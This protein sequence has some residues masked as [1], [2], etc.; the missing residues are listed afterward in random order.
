[1]AT[2]SIGAHLSPPKPSKPGQKLNLYK[3]NSG[4][5][6][7]SLGSKPGPSRPP[8]PPPPSGNLCRTEAHRSPNTK[9][10]GPGMTVCAYLMCWA[11]GDTASELVSSSPAHSRQ[12]VPTP[13]GS[14]QGK[15]QCAHSPL[16]LADPR[17]YGAKPN[18][19]GPERR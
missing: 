2:Y 13:A 15:H 10:A 19:V 16:S 1:V 4:S 5:H 12:P 3:Q 9:M 11:L 14:E 18:E 6:P 8:C 17:A 7:L